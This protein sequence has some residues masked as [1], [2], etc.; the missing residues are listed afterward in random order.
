MKL[1]DN[2]YLSAKPVSHN[3]RIK[4]RVWVD[5]HEFGNV[6]TVAESV[7]P[8]GEQVGE[9]SHTDLHEFFIVRSGS[10]SIKVENDIHELAPGICVVVEPGE[11]H[12]LMNSGDDEL[13]IT[14]FG[15]S[16]PD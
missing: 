12:S 9:H 5:Y 13:V 14:Y 7:F 4:K 10:G 3:T 8:P 16:A 1:I 6:T 2:N 15:I 11:K